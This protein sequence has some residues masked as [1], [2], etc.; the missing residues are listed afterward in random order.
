MKF[1]TSR[2]T[3]DKIGEDIMTS[4][5]LNWSRRKFMLVSA[6]GVVAAPLLTNLSDLVPEGKAAEEVK[7]TEKENT[8][9]DNPRCRGCQMCTIFYSNCLTLNNRVCWCEP[10]GEQVA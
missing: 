1:H 10:A 4:E 2:Q 6:A 5:S 3:T 7:A 9:Y 8:D